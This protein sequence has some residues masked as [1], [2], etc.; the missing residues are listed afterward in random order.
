M[1]TKR[2]KA[3]T[4]QR[5]KLDSKEQRVK[6][7]L[8]SASTD[9]ESQVKRVAIISLVSGVTVL[10]AYGLYRA[11]SHKDE[12]IEEPLKKTKSTPVAKEVPVKRGGFFKN[13]IMERAAVIAL[14]FI[15]AQLSLFLAK[16]FGSNEEE[17]D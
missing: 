13:L 14:N 5:T 9:F 11:F 10:G 6:K 8:E 4:R 12:K 16:K 15:G 3:W 2:S 1:S 7:D 17:G